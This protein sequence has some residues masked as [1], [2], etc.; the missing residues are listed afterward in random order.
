VLSC[1]FFES[2]AHLLALYGFRL[3]RASPLVNENDKHVRDLQSS[4]S[5]HLC[6]D[7]CDQAERC[8]LRSVA[9]L[10]LRVEHRSPAIELHAMRVPGWFPS[11]ISG[12]APVQ[13]GLRPQV[14]LPGSSR[15]NQQGPGMTCREWVAHNQQVG[16]TKRF[17]T[18]LS[19]PGPQLCIP[20]RQGVSE[21]LEFGVCQVVI[22]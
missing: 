16:G 20:T 17:G 5:T 6:R 14:W 12:A 21:W 11:M 19:R 8:H 4:R 1:L 18:E 22:L 13:A 3:T 7:A 2:K 15:R 10:G 9:I